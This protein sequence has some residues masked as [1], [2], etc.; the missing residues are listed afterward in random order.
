MKDLVVDVTLRL[1]GGI[2]TY[3]QEWKVTAINAQVAQIFGRNYE[4]LLGKNFWAVCPELIGSPIYYQCLWAIAHQSSTRFEQYFYVL[5]NWFEVHIYPNQT[6]L[7]AYFQNITER[8]QLETSLTAENI[9]FPE[10]STQLNSQARSKQDQNWKKLLDNSSDLVCRFDHNLRYVYT[11]QA[12]ERAT[13]LPALACIGKTHAEIGLPKQIYSRWD[14]VLGLALKTSQEQ[15][16]E[17]R[18]PT[19]DGERIYKSRI[20]PELNDQGVP[21]YLLVL[22]RD[23]TKIKQA[24]QERSQLIQE[25]AARAEIEQVNR[26]KDEFLAVLSHELR[27]PL[28]PILGWAKLLQTR[29]YDTTTL[30]RGLEIIERNAKIQAQL[31]EELLDVSRIL[32]GKLILQKCPVNLTLT[33]EAAIETVQLVAQAKEVEICTYFHPNVGKVMGDPD[34]L[35]QVVWNLLS[36]AVK[37]TTFGDSIE[38]WLEQIDSQAQITVKD[39]GVGIAPDFLPHIFDSF[40]QADSS[41][42]RSS[43]GLGLGLAIVSN[44]V[45]LHGGTVTAESKGEAQ[46]ATF[47][48]KLP[49]ISTPITEN[50]PH[51]ASSQLITLAGTQILVV[52]DE[53]DSRQYVAFVLEE[54]GAKV[55]TAASATEAIQLFTQLKPDVLISDIGMPDIDGYT[56]LQQIRAW[57]LKPEIPAIALTAYA[58]EHDKKLAYRAGFQHHIPK[59][60]E[61]DK[62]VIVVAKLIQ[63]IK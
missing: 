36:N 6:N 42:T 24:E 35:Q 49:I 57:N 63:E 43:N 1:S 44:L 37:F 27:S 21:E 58:S 17:S 48:V 25:Q 4:D 59:P 33:I 15:L 51:P 55:T 16:I 52:D 34:R 12:V 26:V 56:L 53:A 31:I 40:R 29:Q 18:L 62:L 45:E 23:I 10:F 5:N 46:G 20:V 38:I 2:I 11:N 13:G 32:R 22:S 19:P 7:T 39:H 47:I 3:D 8:K 60:I 9:V 50:Q 28:N 30:N 54:H 61:P 41:I 14:H